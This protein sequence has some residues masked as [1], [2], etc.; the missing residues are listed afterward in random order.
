MVE[1]I[2][3]W[4]KFSIAIVR[5]AI[6]YY[7]TNDCYGREKVWCLKMNTQRLTI[8]NIDRYDREIDL[9]LRNGKTW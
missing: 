6:E 1:I 8:Q 9:Q 4:L 2:D 7:K 3:C 5:K